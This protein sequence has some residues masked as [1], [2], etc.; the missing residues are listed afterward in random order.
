MGLARE[1]GLKTLTQLSTLTDIDY[2]RVP[3]RIADLPLLTDLINAW[4]T[5]QYLPQPTK[6]H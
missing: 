4:T 6:W 3:P 2:A 5:L 1:V